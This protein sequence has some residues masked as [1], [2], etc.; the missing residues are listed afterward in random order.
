MRVTKKKVGAA[1][2]VAAIA[3]TGAASTASNTVAAGAGRLGFSDTV[4]T[5]GT[6]N[7]IN[8]TL[9]NSM[10]GKVIAVKINIDDQTPAPSVRVQMRADGADPLVDPDILTAVITCVRG[11]QTAAAVVDDPL[12]VGVDETAAAKYDYDCTVPTAVDDPLTVGVD[13]ADPVI[14]ADKLTNTYVAIS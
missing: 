8:Y 6:I 3:M 9:D 12:T 2:A 14:A 1:L 5:G 13:E 11:A 4:V 7:A 10:P